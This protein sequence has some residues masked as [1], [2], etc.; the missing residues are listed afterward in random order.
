[1]FLYKKKK[2]AEWFGRR[3]ILLPPYSPFLAPTEWVF[4]STKK[5]LASQRKTK[6]ANLVST[7]ERWWLSNIWWILERHWD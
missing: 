5:L 4:W 7:K 1:M 3:L 2:A 6:N